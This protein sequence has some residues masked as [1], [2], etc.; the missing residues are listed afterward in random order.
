MP[1]SI[2]GR[3]KNFKAQKKQK[4]S[5]SEPKAYKSRNNSAKP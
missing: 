5:G 3:V 1:D 4:A 2:N